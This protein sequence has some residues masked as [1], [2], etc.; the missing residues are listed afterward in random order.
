MISMKNII[1]SLMAFAIVA[2]V[3]SCSDEQDLK[4]ATPAAAF[5]ILTPQY[6]D[7]VVL[8]PETPT[9]PALVMTWEAASVGTPTEITYAVEIDKNGN[10][11]ATPIVLTTTTANFISI[12][13]QTLNGAAIAA[14]LEPF[15]EGGLDIRV[16][17]T[18]GTTSSEPAYS[19]VITYLVT[20]YTTEAP[21]V[22]VVGNFL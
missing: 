1:K 11:F 12:D 9:N 10:D 14:G 18:V 5:N 4:F 2:S 13:M 20:P 17:A 19:N 16:K 21:K 22:Y 8:A 3:T 7:G 15:S 6:G